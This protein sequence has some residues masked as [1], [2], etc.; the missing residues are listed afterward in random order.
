[1]RDLS[2][3]GEVQ[4][5]LAGLAPVQLWTGLRDGSEVLVMADK[6]K[7]LP[8]R[9]LAIRNHSPA[10][11]NWGY[12]GSGPAQLALA[13]L[14]SAGLPDD[15]AIHFYQD[16]KFQHVASWTTEHNWYFTGPNMRHWIEQQLWEAREKQLLA[17]GGPL[18][19]P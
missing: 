5:I 2:D 15:I 16:F 17:E 1:M 12:A 14:L 19:E 11:F 10:G 7:V 9:S 8:G 18:D 3:A 13:L 4:R 6:Q